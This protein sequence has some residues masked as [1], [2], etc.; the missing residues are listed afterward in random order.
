[1]N[2]PLYIYTF[3]STDDCRLRNFK[4]SIEQLKTVDPTADI[5]VVEQNGFTTIPS[6]T[7]H[8]RVDIND[9]KFHKTYLLN[10]AVK[11]HA[12]YTHYVM[13]DADSW[14]DAGVVDNI[15]NHCDDAPLVFPYATCVYLNDAQTR[16]KC[17]HEIVDI[18]L[19]YNAN[20]PITRQTG[21][22]NCFSKE[23]YEQVGGFDEEFVGWG[24]ED[25][26]FVFK[27]RRVTGKKELRCQGGAVLH[28]WHKKANDPLYME[29]IQ[30][31]RNRALCSL[32][33]R[34]TNEEFTRY[35]NKESTLD[36][37]YKDYIARG[38]I[39]GNAVL[40]VGPKL[41]LKVDTSIYYVQSLKPTMTEFL[42]EV[43]FEDGTEYVKYFVYM[44][45]KPED[46]YPHVIKEVNDF[47]TKNG[48]TN[49]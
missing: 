4:A 32:M 23:T 44:Y 34:M 36:D 24:A 25:D 18:P 46:A 19:R 6:V 35:L 29:G 1:M 15:R 14:I 45:I 22:I 3:Y 28:L 37:I 12:E 11:N 8:H 20:I 43:L 27:I 41:S 42:T 21:L 26:A 47:Y 30:Y 40:I 48:I 38:G 49:D 9:S 10:Y 7:Y 33:R 39:E 31:K 16:R 2:R 13:I 5:C 17:R